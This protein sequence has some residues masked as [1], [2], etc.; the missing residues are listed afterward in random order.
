M[1][2][3]LSDTEADS[4]GFLRIG[5]FVFDRPKR[6]LKSAGGQPVSLRRQSADVLSELAKHCGEIVMKDDLVEAVWPNSFVTDDSLVQCVKDIRKALNDHDRTIV[7]TIKG[8]GYLLAAPRQP[9]ANTPTTVPGVF[10]DRV[11]LRGTSQNLLHFAEDFFDELVLV[12]SPRTGVRV[13]TDEAEKGNTDY[14]VRSRASEIGER[15]KVFVTLTETRQQGNFHSEQYELDN[16]EAAKLAAQVARKISSV[17]RINVIAHEGRKYADIADSELDMEQLF[18]KA[19]YHYSLITTTGTEIARASMKA[20]VEREPNNPRALAM[21]AHSTTQ[22]HPLVIPDL[23]DKDRVWALSVADRAVANGPSSSF[24]FR[25]RGNLRLWLL[26]DHK[27]C[28]SDCKRALNIQPNLY[29]IHLTLATSEI[30]SGMPAEGEERIDSYV[31]LTPIDIQYPLFLSLI[32]LSRL[33]QGD[34]AA[35]LEFAREAYE[36]LPAISWYALIY[37]VAGARDRELVSSSRFRSM[38]AGLELGMSHFRAMPFTRVD[39]LT[40][41][42]DRLRAVTAS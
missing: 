24:A 9:T 27:G 12:M 42:E 13:F 35:A 17:L 7:Q 19:H 18:S 16:G 34:D 41:L 30:L 28:R 4:E 1:T 2:R 38:V 5:N 29:L 21:L 40:L 32:A 37:A 20:A 15:I 36:R 39:D 22:M 11:Q 23:S 6:V 14:V 33:F 26:G 25:T 8:K 10:I 31:S 3:N